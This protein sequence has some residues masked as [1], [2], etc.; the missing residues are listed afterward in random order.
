MKIGYE[1]KRAFFNMTGLGNYSRGVI[2]MMATH[3]PDHTYILYT[4]KTIFTSRLDFLHAFDQVLTKTP[5]S[6][7]FPAL[8]RSKSVIKDLQRDNI[9]L[10]HGLSHELPVGI[11]QS[12]IKSVVTI[13]DLIFKR[14]PQYFGFISR[15]IYG[16][17]IKYACKHS[18]KIIAISEKTKN[19]LVELLKVDPEKIE[20][21]YQDCD[22]TF[23]AKQSDHK[24]G[25]VKLKYNLPKN[26][27][28]NVGTIEERKNL[29]LLI[30]AFRLLPEDKKLVVIGKQTKYAEQIKRYIDKHNL[31]S[32]ILLIPNVRFADL[33]AIY[34]LADVFVYTSRYEGFGIPVLEA[35]VSGIPVIAATGSCLEEAGG[36]DSLYIDPDNEAE[37][38]EKINLVLSNEEQ[39][40][41][42]IKKGLI[43]A[44][45]FDEKKLAAQM[46]DIYKNVLNNA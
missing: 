38:A 3:F 37:L 21:V 13:H 8:W 33:P 35:L 7:L 28:L 24:K 34:Q 23:K 29:F 42:M 40:K 2:K 12:G 17:K 26:Y 22:E 27:I 31:R 14:Y 44:Q 16:I 36:P 41:M 1:A 6:K 20:I 9:N 39:R 15:Q 25:E 30:K 46:M 11:H 18:D 5:D 43:Y 4:P 10:Y 45:K 32:R 19:D